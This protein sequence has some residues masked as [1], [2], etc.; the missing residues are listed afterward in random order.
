MPGRGAYSRKTVY[1][2]VMTA[3]PDLDNI[4]NEIRAVVED[5]LSPAA[6]HD[7]HLERDVDHDGDPILRVTIVVE[8]PDQ[9]LDPARV[10]GLIRH[11][12]EPLGDFSDVGFPV[13]SL[14]TPKE[15]ST[16]A[17]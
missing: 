1:I 8:V 11:L 16:E 4:L 13:I 5:Q 2:V 14:R 6:V 7:I 15:F 10:R 3:P 9:G 17:A 12:R